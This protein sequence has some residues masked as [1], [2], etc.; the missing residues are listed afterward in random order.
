MSPVLLSLKVPIIYRV[1]LDCLTINL[2]RYRV[3]NC[4][5]SNGKRLVPHSTEHT[6]DDAIHVNGNRPLGQR[7]DKDTWRRLHDL[8]AFAS[9]LIEHTV[10]VVKVLAGARDRCGGIRD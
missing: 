3:I 9:L 8:I 4:R 2:I 6:V 7:R 5:A 1:D 10:G